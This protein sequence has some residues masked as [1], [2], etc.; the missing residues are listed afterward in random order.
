MRVKDLIIYLQKYDPNLCVEFSCSEC[1]FHGWKA[2]I[3]EDS[4]NKIIKGIDIPYL[5]FD[6]YPIIEEKENLND[7]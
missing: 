3:Y 5:A 6:L 2:E 4:Y 1:N 7:Y